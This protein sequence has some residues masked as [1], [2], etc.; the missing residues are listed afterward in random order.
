MSPPLEMLVQKQVCLLGCVEELAFRLTA[1]PN[2]KG[3]ETV[4]PEAGR[5]CDLLTLS[6]LGGV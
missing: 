1:F 2:V 5:P 3:N 4:V 6:P